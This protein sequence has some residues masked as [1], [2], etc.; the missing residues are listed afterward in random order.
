MTEIVLIAQKLLSK[1]DDLEAR[2]RAELNSLNG[3]E[4]WELAKEVARTTQ[5][6]AEWTTY[7]AYIQKSVIEGWADSD[8][9]EMGVDRSCIESDLCFS[10]TILPLSEF[11]TRT[12]RRKDQSWQRISKRWGDKWD[13]NMGNLLPQWPA[14]GFLRELAIVAEK[15]AWSEVKPKLQK[16]VQVRLAT[17]RTKKFKWLTYRDLELVLSEKITNSQV[18][19]TNS[20][21]RSGPSAISPTISSSPSASAPSTTPTTS[22]TTTSSSPSASASSTTITTSATST[23][24][25]TTL[26]RKTQNRKR[27]KDDEP[28]KERK[29][30][31]EIEVINLDV[32]DRIETMKKEAERQKHQLKLR[33]LK[34]VEKALAYLVQEEEEEENVSVELWKRRVGLIHETLMMRF[35][36]M[37]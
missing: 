37:E 29:V 35:K 22:A 32:K 12:E 31:F 27:S 7:A 13:E 11:Y 19:D 26:V 8:F 1:P 28:R 17:P 16:S 6:Q 2:Y 4:K 33:D 25:S 5:L 30:D 15:M 21:A 18:E 9:R 20:P 3:P 36:D 14:E 23:A 10:A 34:F 24:P